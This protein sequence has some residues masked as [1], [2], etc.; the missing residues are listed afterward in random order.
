MRVGLWHLLLGAV[1]VVMLAAAPIPHLDSDAPL[2]ARI[3]ANVLAT[4]DWLTFHH[5][6]W[7]VDKPP[8]VFWLMA[9]SFRLFGIS[10]ATIR[11]WQI[12]LA[13][14]LLVVVYHLA[15]LGGAGREEALLATLVF[16][17]ALQV[18]YQ[19]TVPQQDVP[20][21]L[22]LTLALVFA[23]RFRQRPGA[24]AGAA[25]GA[26]VALAVL[27]KGVAGLG[28]FAVGLA[29][30]WLAVRPAASQ[31]PPQGSPARSDT[32]PESG[33]RPGAGATARGVLAAAVVFALVAV[34]W[35]AHGVVR[36][37]EP[38]V[39]TFLT[40]GTLGVGRYFT[41]AISEPPPYLLALFAYVPLLLLGLLP[42]S[43]ALALAVAAPRRLLRPASWTFRF[44]AAWGLALFVLLSASSGDK[45]FRYL[46]PVYPVAAVVS[47]RVLVA[48]LTDRRRLAFAGLLALVPGV[49][50]AA[51][52][53]WVLW[54][55][56]PPE[57]DLLAAIVLPAV[58][59]LAAGLVGF[60]VAALLG[61]GRPA[62][63]LAAALALAGFAAFERGLVVHRAAVDPW[64]A[65]VR[66]AD[67]YR[68][69]TSRL[70]LYGRA[71]EAFNFAHFHFDAP[72]VAVGTP[73]E[74]AGLWEREA[75]LIIAPEERLAEL[76]GALQPAPVL[77]TRTPARL[78]LLRNP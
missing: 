7:L 50:L 13:L 47:A 11:L 27:T 39:R 71:G 77:V 68:A 67:P 53:F 14:A 48:A 20:L 16:G 54:R 22:F 18:L 6:G 76:N 55:Q 30:A 42:W 72:V 2:Y 43:P 15:V 75:V 60:G 45:V 38:F 59:L 32:R 41:P 63:A 56:F 17:T 46:L 44:T 31:R 40:S 33:A 26:A 74:L 57:R 69:S 64:P 25:A 5:P 52:G 1:A 19:V 78:V 49:A 66:A 61:R 58:G 12:V 29:G 24:G 23:I 10:D 70:V 65:L 8:V 4:G 51:A 62:I 35:F 28:L 21:T 9:G 34:P 37:G 3:A 73:A 36:H